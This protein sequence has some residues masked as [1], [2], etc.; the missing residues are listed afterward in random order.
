MMGLSEQDHTQTVSSWG[1]VMSG[2][3]PPDVLVSPA[4]VSASETRDLLADRV[5]CLGDVRRPVEPGNARGAEAGVSEVMSVAE[6]LGDLV[7]GLNRKQ[8]TCARSGVRVQYATS[9]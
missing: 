1:L 6:R 7:V 3:S 4:T 8:E 2:T 5:S 9:Y